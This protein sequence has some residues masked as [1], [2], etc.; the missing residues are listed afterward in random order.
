MKKPN[1]QSGATIVEFA[2]VFML[3]LLLSI[4]LFEMGRAM[5]IYAVRRFPMRRAR[6]PE[7]VRD[8]QIGED[9]ASTCHS[10]PSN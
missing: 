7:T 1:R 10:C 4:G 6:A 3:F 9:D 8:G 2:L 5:W